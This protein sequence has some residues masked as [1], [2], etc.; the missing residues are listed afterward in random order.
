MKVEK[1]RER[2]KKKKEES[3]NE[4]K[5][6]THKLNKNCFGYYFEAVETNMRRIS[7][8]WINFGFPRLFQQNLELKADEKSAEGRYLVDQEKPRTCDQGFF[9]ICTFQ[10]RSILQIYRWNGFDILLLQNSYKTN[11]FRNNYWTLLESKWRILCQELGFRR[12]S[13]L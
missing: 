13:N 2:E 5:I 3:G 4:G 8:L 1:E 10:I 6:I 12:I 7:F 11:S 9:E